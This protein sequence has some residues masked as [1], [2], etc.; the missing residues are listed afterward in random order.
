MNPIARRSTLFFMILG[1]TL[2][3]V[4]PHVEAAS[5]KKNAVARKLHDLRRTDRARTGSRL[6]EADFRRIREAL[7]G[8]SD[9]VAA[10]AGNRVRRIG[11]LD[12]SGE[13]AAG[14]R[15]R[16]DRRTGIPVFLKLKTP[17]RGPTPRFYSPARSRDKA[18]RFLIDNRD[19]LKLADPASELV[20]RRQWRDRAGMVHIRYRQTFRD[21][22]LWGREAAVHMDAAGDVFLFQGGHAPT[23]QTV[24]TTPVLSPD[25]A[26][27]IVRERV[28]MTGDGIEPP[29]VGR[30]IHTDPNGNHRLAYKVEIFPALDRRWRYFVDA[31][32]GEI[33]SRNS[34]VATELAAASGDDLIGETERFTVWREDGDYFLVDPTV[35]LDDPPYDPV[36]AIRSKG[37]TYVF[38]ARNGD[39]DLYFIASDRR[40]G[41][42]DPAGVS[43]ADHIAAFHAYYRN[44]FGRNG[45]DDGNLNYL[46]VVHLLADYPNAFWNGKF[47]VFGDGDGRTFGSLAAG[48]DIAAHELQHGVTQFSTG[49]IYENQSGALTEALSDIFAC[50]VDRDD[51][52]VGE[53]VVLTAPGYLRNLADP[54]QGLT[55]LP[56][57]MSEYRNLP[58]TESG[59]WGGVHINMSI[60][61]RAAYLMA[62]GLTVE[63]LGTGIGRSKTEQI[64]YRAMTTYLQAASRFLEARFATV[65]AAEDLYGPGSPEVAAVHDAW[66]AVEV[67]DDAVNAPGD[68]T[69]TPAIP[70][71]GRDLMLYLSPAAPDV[72]ALHFQ[73]MP[74]PFTGYDPS[75]DSAVLNRVPALGTR[76]AAVTLAEGTLFFYVGIDGNL[77]GVLPDGGD[78]RQLTATGDIFSF[79]ISPRGRFFAYTSIFPEDS[80][81]YVGDLEA[82]TLTEYPVR[83]PTDLPPGQEGGIDTILFADALAF[84]YTGNRIVFDA[85]NCI[86]TA[87]DPCGVDS[88]HRYWSIG[89]LELTEGAFEFPFTNQDPDIDVAYPA[90]A[91]NNDFVI[92]MDEI[93]RTGAASG[94]PV[95]S[96]VATLNRLTRTRQVVADPDPNTED[97]AVYGVPSF[98]GGDDNVAIQATFGPETFAYR[99]PVTADWSGRPSEADLLNP[100]PAAMPLMHR[101]GVRDLS[102]EIRAD[103]AALD[104]GTA[105]PGETR[106]RDLTL[107]NP[108]SRDIEIRDIAVTGSAAF[109]H[110]GVNTR[111]PRNQSVVFQVFFTPSDAGSFSGT[112]V[113]A[114][115]TDAAQVEIPLS[116]RTAPEGDGD[117]LPPDTDSDDGGGG[118]CFIGVSK[119]GW[120]P[121]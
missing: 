28:G 107:T 104:F 49:L 60:P 8:L 84:D 35:P 111:L 9:G 4:L 57:R 21:I 73:S 10:P 15:V 37:N 72:Y 61:A 34:R 92:V 70:V 30:V 114:N 89:I 108:G 50:M 58:N 67:F 56:T 24:E 86:N 113:A 118:G 40:D 6:P 62:E 78:H 2:C 46:A 7:T 29:G 52:T 1:L 22:P 20:P 88:G 116:G 69:P 17:R 59:D 32:T 3:L 54:S 16:F 102:G 66:D 91:Y 87:A 112:L 74:R 77:Y 33:L 48:L 5:D 68:P 81:I 115:N 94:G 64:F 76:P 98:W 43:A 51:W 13:S 99:V 53:D 11:A 83:P 90:F 75:L 117:G 109:T 110:N 23:P 44:T 25:S 101:A 38:D 19:L 121:W 47:V 103:P 119:T 79:A 100:N 85:L 18:A 26:V 82:D 31:R 36:P 93:D 39:S 106:V 95:R 55:P 14:F 71:D 42:W 97:E 27:D 63:G 80:N 105:A 65:Q 12:A 96:R 45:L 120:R 41:G